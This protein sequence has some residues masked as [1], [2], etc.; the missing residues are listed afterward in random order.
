LQTL[1]DNLDSDVFDDASYGLW[2]TI[3]NSSF[4]GSLSKLPAS[5]SSSAL[6]TSSHFNSSSL[7]LLNPTTIQK[8]GLQI[9][10]LSSIRKERLEEFASA[11][12]GLSVFD[13]ADVW[14]PVNR[15]GSVVEGLT[16]AFSVL[17]TQN[18]EGLN[19]FQSASVGCIVLP[20]S[21]AIG[22][23]FWSGN[24]VWSTNKVSESKLDFTKIIYF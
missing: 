23:A 24:P 2:N 14:V 15:N 1:V 10:S 16:H 5:K 13:A 22:Q 21:G 12:L 19:Q 6:V 20:W 7:T 11:F 3:M 9:Q 8:Y 18:N 17:V 4:D